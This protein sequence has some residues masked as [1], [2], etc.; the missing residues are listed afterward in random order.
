MR[1][2]AIAKDEGR[3]RARAMYSSVP[4]VVSRRLFKR[5]KLSRGPPDSRRDPAARLS[6]DLG[7]PFG[8]NTLL[9]WRCP[10]GS[11]RAKPKSHNRQLRSASSSRLEHFTSR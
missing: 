10:C 3:M 1:P 8:L 9:V 6:S 4:H 11:P 7:T 2:T 5:L